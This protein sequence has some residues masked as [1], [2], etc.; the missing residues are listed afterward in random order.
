[1]NRRTFMMTGAWL[2]GVAGGGAWPALARTASHGNTL[3]IVDRTLSDGPAF[4]RYAA[5]MKLPLFDTG[6]D[7]GA[8]WYTVLA[9]R[10]TPTS[11][12][13]GVT[14]GSSYFVLHEFVSR[15]GLCA[16]YAGNAGNAGQRTAIVFTFSPRACRRASVQNV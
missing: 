7:I 2:S 13:I 5:Q 3:A 14:R 15:A 12:L 16:D 6:D 11:S 9:P 4:A 1:M 8:L 10:L